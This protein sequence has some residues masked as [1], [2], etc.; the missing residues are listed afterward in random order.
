MRW[1]K[2]DKSLNQSINKNKQE[3]DKKWDLWLRFSIFKE[4]WN[5]VYTARMAFAF[6]GISGPQVRISAVLRLPGVEPRTWPPSLTFLCWIQLF[7]KT[8]WPGEFLSFLWPPFLQRRDSNLVRL[9]EKHERY[10][11]AM[12]SPNISLWVTLNSVE[13]SYKLIVLVLNITS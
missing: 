9:V 6:L 2:I 4:D 3:N 8:H 12:P 7:R 13:I 11:C 1:K 10:L 5:L